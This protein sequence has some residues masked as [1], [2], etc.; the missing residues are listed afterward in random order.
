MDSKTVQTVV[1]M[2][3]IRDRFHDIMTS[4]CYIRQN[5]KLSISLE[6]QIFKLPENEKDELM[7]LIETFCD[8]KAR[9]YIKM[10]DEL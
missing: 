3:E 8:I 10:L 6:E 9:K 5:K 1:N 7:Q 2:V 4:M